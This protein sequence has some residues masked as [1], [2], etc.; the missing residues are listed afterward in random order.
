M[1]LD[2]YFISGSPFAWRVH[3][4]LEYKGIPYRANLLKAS[5]GELKS[6]DFLQLNP[7]GRV[8]VL[9]DGKTIVYESVAI[10]AYLEAK[11]PTP[12][13]FGSSLAETGHIWQ[14]VHEIEN[15]ARNPFLHVV[16][17]ILSGESNEKQEELWELINLCRE[18]LRWIESVLSKSP[19]I[20]GEA[21]SAADFVFYPVIKIF[22]RTAG[23]QEK[24][25]E[26]FVEGFFEARWP[27]TAEW[28]VKIE[29]LTGYSNTY[30]PHWNE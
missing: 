5:D 4:A 29:E 14:R 16:I 7:R 17:A 20:G 6:P 27:A 11:Y 19:W 2:F 8:P 24:G 3:L 28:A 15:Y 22:L 21:I 26:D 12:H 18:Q 25:Y 9:R 30:P 10:L 13:L 1:S 23:N